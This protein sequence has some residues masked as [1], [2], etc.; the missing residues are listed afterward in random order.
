LGE[1]LGQCSHPQK[2]ASVAGPDFRV[3]WF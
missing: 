3:C 1:L 2:A